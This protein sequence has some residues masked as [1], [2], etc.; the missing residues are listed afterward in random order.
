VVKRCWDKKEAMEGS[1][2]KNNYQVVKWS[3]SEEVKR[4]CGRL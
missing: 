1:E 3:E 4:P 2:G